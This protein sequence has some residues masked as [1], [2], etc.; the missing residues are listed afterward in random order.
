[1]ANYLERADD[2]FQGRDSSLTEHPAIVGPI[3]PWAAL[4]TDLSVNDDAFAKLAVVLYRASQGLG[5]LGKVA[6][7]AL[8]VVCG[9][10]IPSAVQAGPGLRLPH[11]GRGVVVHSE[12]VL[13]S[14]VTILHG[15]TVGVTAAGQQ[16]PR[17]E[18]GVYV[19]A[20][21]CVLG[22]VTLGAHSKVGANSV[23][24]KDV[25]AGRTAVGIPTRIL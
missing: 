20:G 24:L 4:R 21:A 22:P 17:L 11:G 5:P 8:R 15:V 7:I 13:G 18:D 14:Y 25:P 9:T 19:G 23:V 2:D 1:M 3:S 16:A 6:G 12:A 10:D